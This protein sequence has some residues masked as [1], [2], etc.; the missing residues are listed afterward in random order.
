M[1]KQFSTNVDNYVENYVNKYLIKLENI[2]NNHP[3]TTYSHFVHIFSTALLN[4]KYGGFS[5]V[6]YIKLLDSQT[7]LF[8][9]IN[10]PYYY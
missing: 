5:L 4:I 1:K 3:K 9:F 8:L 7:S 6:K 10:T 2:V